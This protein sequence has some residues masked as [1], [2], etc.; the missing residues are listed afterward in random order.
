MGVFRG[1]MSRNGCAAGL[2][3]HTVD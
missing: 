1:A 3:D 2:A